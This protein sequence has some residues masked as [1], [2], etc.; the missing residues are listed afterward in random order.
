MWWHGV[1]AESSRNDMTDNHDLRSLAELSATID[2][3]QQVFQRVA[4]EAFDRLEAI[5]PDFVAALLE[6]FGRRQAAAS[7]LARTQF[8]DESSIYTTLAAGKRD[9]VM[10][11]LASVTHG[12]F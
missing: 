5:D 2:S 1:V 4:D 10:E 3:A 7:Y 6:L 12:I 11:L 8:D 9:R